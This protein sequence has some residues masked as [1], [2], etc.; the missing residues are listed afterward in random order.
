MVNRFNASDNVDFAQ[1]RRVYGYKDEN[2][3][4][5]YDED[6]NSHRNPAAYSIDVR[7]EKQFVMGKVSSGAFFEIFNLLNTDDIRVFEIDNRANTL[8]ALETRD[9]GRRFQFGIKMNF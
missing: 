5:F 1:T 7:T 8:Q 6:R 3:G 2:T 4:L 9:F